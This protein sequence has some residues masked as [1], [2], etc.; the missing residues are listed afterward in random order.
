[1]S[2]EFDVS[3]HHQRDS[4]SNLLPSGP[5]PVRTQIWP[6]R[7]EPDRAGGAAGETIR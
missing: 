5:E 4:Q 2:M 6:V 7:I 3:L 1:M